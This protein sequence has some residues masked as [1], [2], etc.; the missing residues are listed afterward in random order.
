M[1]APPAFDA[2][3]EKL[4]TIHDLGKVGSLLA[5]DQQTQMPPLGAEARA[6]HQ[7]TIARLAHE[8]F[9][10][11]EIGQLLDE[12]EPWA[13]TLPYES[14]EASLVRMTRRDHE[15]ALR[16]PPSL[17]QEFS[18]TTSLAFGVW[19]E[20]KQ[21]SDYEK[22][23][24][25][26][27]RVVDLERRYID[28]FP[29]ADEP[30]DTLLDDYEPGMKTAEVREV[31]ARLKEGLVPLV[32]SLATE[33]PVRIEG[34]FPAAT[35][36][37]VARELIR[38]FGFAE[39]SWRLDIAAHPF[40]SSLSTKDIRI[41]SWEPEDTPDG[42]FAVMH[43]AGHGL[44]EHGV[45][46][47]L[48]RTPL[49]SGASYGFHE[50]Q[51]RLWENLVGRSRPFASWFYP[52]LQEAFPQQLADVDEETWYRSVNQVTPSLIRVEA[53]EV[54]YSLHVILRFELEQRILAGDADLREL[55]QEWNAAMKGYLGIDVP[56]DAHGVLQDVHW[57]GGSFGY[58]P[59]YALGNVIGAQIWERLRDDVPDVD[60][61]IARG[62]FG[63]IR[64]WLREHVHRH[65]RKFLPGELLERVVGGPL[66][67][68]PYLRY[69]E[70][71][72][73]LA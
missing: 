25:W 59:T 30:Y 54:T 15:K 35:Q 22:F 70:G 33:S 66:D 56:D 27:E 52:R 10:A 49:A 45:D 68:E 55:P 71:K 2:L 53:D 5:W 43:E 42:L 13:E 47:A 6:H 23:R 18:Q 65:G 11:D 21:E 44:Y 73:A 31:F 72:L 58:F 20:A 57:S 4:A 50:S 64:E 12:V 24:P 60:E 62:E 39:G 17:T 19:R 63:P 36:R 29:P 32:E 69:L 51:S 61:Q 7:S 38:S 16:V 26:L 8:S 67:P 28:C 46:P 9:V 48:E 1:T 14:D 3:R 40:E 34:H 41:T 37:E